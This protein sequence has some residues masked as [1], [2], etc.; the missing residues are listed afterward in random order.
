MVH[1]AMGLLIGQA[2]DGKTLEQATMV[3][4]SERGATMCNALV[5]AA[6]G[7]RQPAMPS[8]TMRVNAKDRGVDAE[9][10]VDVAADDG[11]RPAPILVPGWNVF[12]YKHRDAARGRSAVVSD[13]R[14][15]I[16]GAVSQ[17]VERH[18]GR[19]PASYTLMVNID[20]LHAQKAI[21]HDAL[22][23]GLPEQPSTQIAILGAAELAALLNDNPHLRAAFFVPDHFMTWDEA[24][25][26]HRAVMLAGAAGD[27]LVGRVDEL[28]QLRALVDDERVAAI[29]LLGPPGIGKSRL[30]LEATA[31]RTIDTVFFADPRSLAA[32][33]CRSLSA[34]HRQTIVVADN[35]DPEQVTAIV[36]EAL[37]EPNLKLLATVTSLDDARALAHEF[38]ERVRVI[39]LRPFDDAESRELVRVAGP[40]LDFELE[41]WIVSHADG[42]PGL[43]LAAASVGSRLRASTEALGEFSAVVGQELE[44]RALRIVGK[45]GVRAARMLSVLTHVGVDGPHVSELE[46]ITEALGD[47]TQRPDVLAQVGD[48][49]R[50]GIARRGGSFITVVPPLLA[51]HLAAGLL[52]GKDHELFS[53]F[54]ALNESGRVRFLERLRELEPDVAETFWSALFATDGLLGS[55][56]SALPQ[57]RLLP[58]IV[59]AVPLRVLELLERG[60]G[61]ATLEECRA[62]SGWKRRAVVEALEQ[63]AYRPSTSGRALRLVWR[64]ATVENED[65]VNSASGVLAYS[66]MPLAW[67]MPLPLDERLGLIREFTAEDAPPL[68]RLAAI[69]ALERVLDR[70]GALLPLRTSTGRVPLGLRPSFTASDLLDYARG[71]ADLLIESADAGD[72]DVALAARSILPGVLRGL[73][74]I[75]APRDAADRFG[76]LVTW[77]QSGREGLDIP[78][79]ARE[80]DWTR[81]VLAR[82]TEHSEHESAEAK[83]LHVIVADLAALGTQLTEG[84]FA[85]KLRRWAGPWMEGD[86]A[87]TNVP[88]RCYRYQVELER[89][90]EETAADP[91]TLT[92]HLVEWLISDKATKAQTFFHYLGLH[93]NDGTHRPLVVEIG[94]R[95]EAAHVFSAYWL[96]WYHRDGP[97]AESALDELIRNGDEMATSALVFATVAL[98]PSEVGVERLRYLQSTR[99]ADPGFTARVLSTS[100]WLHDL[101]DEQ[102]VASSKRR[103]LSHSGEKPTTSMRLR[104]G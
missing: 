91:T 77:A 26:K 29:V 51:N 8:F 92:P 94:Q 104:A 75:G 4:P 66:L 88:D 10:T 63:L 7:R 6:S 90:A 87:P 103:L 98:G 69:E 24:L 35:P 13:L 83:E 46:H 61:E 96:G 76:C 93:D 34:R 12:Q 52:R 73:A 11:S 5:W 71:I 42:L 44:A 45:D 23:E 50:V 53:L 82:R 55:F 99:D 97:G 74:L 41:D 68:G 79:L 56:D 59:D 16:R 3:W 100:R 33:D 19:I 89:L 86:N 18:D 62:I 72:Q 36:D 27:V 84:D 21:L 57:R 38:D 1:W 31:H 32:T 48:L 81:G 58:L 9:W 102:F 95:P 78:T 47:G 17:V 20:L 80:I 22:A 70:E 60:V 67:Q 54:G 39:R 49:D 15:S 65:W 25:K 30:A 37:V 40:S 64:L 85:V 14:R 101:T 28:G 43:L 2:I